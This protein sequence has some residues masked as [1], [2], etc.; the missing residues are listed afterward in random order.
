MRTLLIIKQTTSFGW[1]ILLEK[2]MASGRTTT[3]LVASFAD[4]PTTSVL[5]TAV[6]NEMHSLYM[7]DEIEF[8]AHNASHL[9]AVRLRQLVQSLAA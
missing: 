9:T 3:A 1:N 2:T 7:P 5:V 6:V 4:L 8:D